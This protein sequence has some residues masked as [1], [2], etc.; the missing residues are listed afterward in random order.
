MRLIILLLFATIIGCSNNRD[1]EPV[2]TIK[3]SLVEVEGETIEDSRFEETLISLNASVDRI[4]DL[5]N[6]LDW[7]EHHKIRLTDESDS[8]IEVSGGKPELNSWAGFFFLWSED[9]KYRTFG[10]LKQGVLSSEEDLREILCSFVL[11]SDA[12]K[13]KYFNEDNLISEDNL[14]GNQD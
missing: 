10:R 5:I 12:W 2:G 3:L 6:S 14:I 1:Y 13:N 9:K 8:F 7:N 4:N 11:N